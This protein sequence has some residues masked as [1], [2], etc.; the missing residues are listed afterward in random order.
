MKKIAI[1]LVAASLFAGGIAAL[2]T[3]D[4]PENIFVYK[5]GNL[6]Y[7]NGASH[8]DSIALEENKG[9]ITIY[10][11]AK[12]VMYSAATA[13]VD[14]ATF[15]Y[16]APVA[17]L[18]DIRFNEDGTVYDASPMH[19]AVE[20][21]SPD[22]KVS[23]TYNE[24]YGCY[25]GNF[26]NN[27]GLGNLG[28]SPNYCKVDYK[29]NQAF[30]D[31]LLSGHTVETLFLA[32]YTP[33]IANEEAKMFSSHEAGG[34]GIF[35]CKTANNRGNEITFL[36]NVTENGNSTWRW[37]TSGIVP[38]PLTYY[39]VVG[40]WNKEEK[41]AQI[42]VNGE[43]KNTVAAPGNLRLAPNEAARWF[44]VGCDAG[45]NGGQFG[46]DWEIVTAKVYGKPLS[47]LD[48]KTIYNTKYNPSYK[49]EPDPEPGKDLPVA[50]LLDIR[51]NADGTATDISPMHNAVE[52]HTGDVTTI[53]DPAFGGY[54]AR[55]NNKWSNDQGVAGYYK[56]DYENNQKFKDALADGHSLEAIVSGNWDGDLSANNREVKFLSSHEAGGTGL[57]L[58]TT[59]CSRGQ[60]LTY[61][62][63][64]TTNGN[65]QWQWGNSG[66]T[67]VK[68]DYY[69]IIGVWNK[70]EGKGY[71][72]VNGELKKTF[73][74]AGEYRHATAGNRWFGIGC[75]AG[76]TPQLAWKGNVAVARVYD[77]PLNPEEVAALWEDAGEKIANVV[78]PMVS[79]IS[80]YSGLAMKSGGV[81]TING[82]GFETGDIVALMAINGNE[83]PLVQLPT[84]LIEGGV[85]VTLP[86]SAV[87]GNYRLMLMRGE[88]LQ[89]LGQIKLNIVTEIPKGADVVAHRGY[90]QTEGSAQ[91]SRA[92]MHKAIELGAYAVETDIWLT[93]DK[94][95]MINHDASFG[96]VSI[97]NST[98]ATCKNLTL[99]NGEKM[100]M[101]QD[102]LDILK[103][104]DSPIKLFIEIKEHSSADRDREAASAAVA[105]VKANGLQDKVE[106]ISF[107]MN[108]CEQV[109]A[110]DPEAQVAYIKGGVAPEVL[111]AKG[112]TGINYHMAEFRSHPEWVK[113][114][115]DLGMSVT[116]WTLNSSYDIID[117]M[118]LGV[119]LVTTD[120]PV[121]AMAIRDIYRANAK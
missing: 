85:R 7:T 13:D 73:N 57:M 106:Y 12:K 21:V 67:P 55:F 103:A 64:V 36:P 97:Q 110:D 119:D 100:P 42:Y 25:S 60:E 11:T 69:H 68:G 2:A 51:F 105:L 102:F 82:N 27:W 4:A 84:A 6:V 19:N 43:L 50:E 3:G 46:G 74:T 116:A 33:P 8:P 113:Q 107:S 56:V 117:M 79:E 37:A 1:S 114:A 91:N 94:Q 89:D 115:H 48:I 18:L 35:I 26:T 111:H 45:P 95:L 71:V 112:Y 15:T 90:W 75:D 72:Y 52:S 77:K 104:T 53:Y 62:V 17:D 32:R 108:A 44:A 66:I 47:E 14:S 63:N 40:V 20:V 29:S 93:T 10:D 81:L 65:S 41:K 22:G 28:S 120:T 118:N 70:A 86:E 98:S 101:L 80:F 34:T 96:G 5:D 30:M 24:I 99:A 49:P 58:C 76:P 31:A 121:N 16:S 39:H 61:L 92:G 23:T 54:I 78:P 88:S 9:R 59:S 38:Q 83:A 87:S 109:I